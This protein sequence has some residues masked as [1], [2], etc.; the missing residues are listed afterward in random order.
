M[1]TKARVWICEF[2]CQHNE[3]PNKV[4]P[5]KEQNPCIVLEKPKKGK[6]GN[7]EEQAEEQLLI[8]VIDVSPS[9]GNSVT[10][11]LSRLDCVR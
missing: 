9:M 6:K 8:F 4:T 11:K 3:L 5:P 1:T 7:K 10:N 2:C